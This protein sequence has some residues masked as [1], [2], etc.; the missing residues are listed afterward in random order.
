MLLVLFLLPWFVYSEDV[1]AEHML[2]RPLQN[3]KLVSLFS[4]ST[5]TESSGHEE[6]FQLFPKSL[7]LL[8][9]RYNVNEMNVSIAGGRWNFKQWGVSPFPC[10]TGVTVSATFFGDG[11]TDER[12]E[13]L[14]EALGGMICAS[15][16]FIRGQNTAPLS[17]SDPTFRYGVVSR[18]IICTENLTPWMNL[19]PCRDREG[20]GALLNPLKI[21]DTPH[22]ALGVSVMRHGKRLVLRQNLLF[23]ASSK[24]FAKE[25]ADWNPGILFGT[26]TV[27][28]CTLSKSSYV[29]LD[30]KEHTDVQGSEEGKYEVIERQPFSFNFS[31][32]RAQSRKPVVDFVRVLTGIGLERGGIQS[33]I[34]NNANHSIHVKL[35]EIIPW[36]LNVQ[37]HTLTMTS[38][39]NE[40]VVPLT[41]PRIVPGKPRKS[42]A[43]LEMEFTV[44]AQSVVVVR[45]DFKKQFLHLSEHPP[46]SHHGMYISGAKLEFSTF[47]LFSDALV[48]QLATPDFSMPFNV[49]TL[50]GIIIGYFFGAILGLLTTSLSDLKHGREIQSEK[51]I[52]R[53]WRKILRKIDGK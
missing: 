14:L 53:I 37:F 20:F 9:Q 7:G 8:L 24:A 3:G 45:Y 19:L 46:D 4:F 50:S 49:V 43:V 44:E 16:S 12:W 52:A 18:E 13:G 47:V 5:D 25:T 2:I 42:P 27:K 23:V 35:T 22:H 39:K 32:P 15:T 6:D 36:F 34:Q 26:A 33:A 17:S 41:K 38:S 51:P 29:T 10:N 21:F 48:V 28:K 30:F 1:F 40:K 11:E 31:V